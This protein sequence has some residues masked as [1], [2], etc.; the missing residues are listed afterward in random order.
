[1]R[2]AIGG[3]YAHVSPVM[4]EQL[5]GRLQGLWEATLDQRFALSPMSPV[6]VLNELLAERRRMADLGRLPIVSRSAVRGG[7]A[8]VP[9]AVPNDPHAAAPKSFPTSATI[10]RVT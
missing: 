3:T 9:M 5:R 8:L 7:L 4:R 6:P 1:M 2:A 10:R